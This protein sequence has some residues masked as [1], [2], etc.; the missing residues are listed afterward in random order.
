MNK[1]Y[2]WYHKNPNSL[3]T[4]MNYMPKNWKIYKKMDKFLDAY[5]L[6]KIKS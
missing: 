1:E 6:T 4:V 3:R 5:N 2:I